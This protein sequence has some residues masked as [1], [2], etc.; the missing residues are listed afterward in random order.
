MSRHSRRR[1]NRAT[2]P[3]DRRLESRPHRR[4]W[5]TRHAPHRVRRRR[6]NRS[7]S[8]RARKRRKLSTRAA[9]RATRAR[10]QIGRGTGWIGRGASREALSVVFN[11]RSSGG[12]FVG[13]HVSPQQRVHARLVPRPL[14]SKPLDDV[15]IDAQRK[16]YLLRNDLQTLA[17][18]SAGKHFWRPLRCICIAGDVSVDGLT[19]LGRRSLHA[20]ERCFKPRAP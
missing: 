19:N 14:P 10:R 13:F 7:S 15:S 8:V 6:A 9:N 5:C 18:N 17:R 20:G 16:E 2:G 11:G 3:R 12:S 1:R 4:L